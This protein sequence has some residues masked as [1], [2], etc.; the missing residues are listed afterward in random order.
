[1]PAGDY[2]I[3]VAHNPDAGITR[4][5]LPSGSKK[6]RLCEMWLMLDRAAMRRS[7]PAAARRACPA[8]LGTV[9][10]GSG[11]WEWAV[12]RGSSWELRLSKQEL[13]VREAAASTIWHSPQLQSR[14]GTQSG[15]L[16]A[17]WLWC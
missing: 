3:I 2:A 1:M 9:E 8:V 6:V 13:R 11:S 16:C 14:I 4:I 10:L 15:P 7:H 17:A 5:K 12:Q